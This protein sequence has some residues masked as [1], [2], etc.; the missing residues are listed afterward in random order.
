METQ[1]NYPQALATLTYYRN[2]DHDVDPQLF[3]RALDTAIAAIRSVISKRQ[4]V[5]T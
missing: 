5:I 3:D 2:V 1:H 4:R